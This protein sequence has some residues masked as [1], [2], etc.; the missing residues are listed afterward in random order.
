MKIDHIPGKKDILET[1]QRIRNKIHRTPVLT[2][3]YLNRVT[4]CNLYFK[5]ENF[6]KVGAFKARGA[7]N[8][9]FSLPPARLSNGI[10]T[11]SSGNHAQ[12]LAY[13]ASLLNIPAYVIM[14]RNAPDVK[15]EAVRT[16][17][18]N[19]LFCEPTLEAREKELNRVVDKT[20]AYF[21]HPYNDYDVIAGQAT[22]AFELFEQAPKLDAVIT[23]VGGGGLLSGTALARNHFS[24]DTEVF[25]GEPEGARDAWRSLKENKIIPSINPVTIADGLL[26]SLGTRTYPIIRE[27]VQRILLVSDE[28]IIEA[29]KLIWERMKIIV[30]PSA[31]VPLAALQKERSYFE[32]RHVGLILSGGNVDITHLPF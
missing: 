29:M 7:I 25:A 26:T 21:I 16:Y 15:I 5:C 24:D 4:G 2:S 32:N 14:P 30:E 1:F 8:A 12:A 3:R 18:A 13:A 11:H 20:G 28:E 31:A 19:I 10:A 27:N 6:Q 17:G 23:P 9:S 22:C